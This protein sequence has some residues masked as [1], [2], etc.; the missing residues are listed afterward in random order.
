MPWPAWRGFLAQPIP[1]HHELRLVG[2]NA[3]MPGNPGKGEATGY[4]AAQFG[5]LI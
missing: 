1:L 2:G 5:L 4:H 3:Q